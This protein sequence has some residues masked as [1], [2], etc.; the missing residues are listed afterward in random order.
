MGKVYS[1]CLFLA[2]LLA[3]AV[4]LP[5]SARS[6]TRPD[7]Q[8]EVCDPLADYFLGMEDYSEAIR[9]HIQVIK[10][11]PDN[12]LAHYHLGFA[13]GLTGQH[14][15]ELREYQK[16]VDLGLSDWELFL[17]LGLLYLE[18][19]HLSAATQILQLATLLG[20]VQPET[21]FNLA[22]AYEQRGMLA[23]AEQELLLALKLDPRQADALNT[24]GVIYAEQ[25]DYARARAE[26]TELVGEVPDY[27]PARDNLA[28]LKRVEGGHLKGE[29]P[30]EGF[31]HAR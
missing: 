21:H 5:V 2:A 13:Y 27:E 15:K 9:R 25:G 14:Q 3:L 30:V 16:A 22:L 11:H 4:W 10:Q 23:Q 17:N 1:F 18:R 12:A 8:E 31:S 29:M 19:E 20:P 7:V 6:A 24:L 26:W 28:I